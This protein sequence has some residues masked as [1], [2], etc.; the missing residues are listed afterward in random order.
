MN[1]R[2][3][4]SSR[5]SIRGKFVARAM[6]ALIDEGELNDKLARLILG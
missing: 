3:D 1:H 2:S 4:V 5:S 6:L